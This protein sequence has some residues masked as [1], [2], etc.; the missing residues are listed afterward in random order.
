MSFY[1]SSNY[2]N[3]YVVNITGPL[4]GLPLGP[5]GSIGPQGPTGSIG[6]TGAQGP[7]GAIGPIGGTNSQIIFNNSNFNPFF[8]IP[9][10]I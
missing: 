5:T 6:P 3:L 4:N 9:P 10:H 8:Y 7:T 2:Q 1:Y